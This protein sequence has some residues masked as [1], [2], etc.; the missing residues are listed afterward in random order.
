[1]AIELIGRRTE[2][3]SARA[4]LDDLIEGPATLRIEGEAGIG[5]TAVFNAA[6]KPPRIAAGG[7]C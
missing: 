7:R 2:I 5:K 1:V 3:E 6:C 4:F